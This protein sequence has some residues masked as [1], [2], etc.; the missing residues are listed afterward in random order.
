VIAV[1]LA[2]VALLLLAA[3]VGHLLCAR[4]GE[5]APAWAPAVGLA[6]LLVLARVAIE[7]PGRATTAALVVGVAGLACLATPGVRAALRAGGLERLLLALGVLLVASLPFL[8]NGRA[9]ILGMGDN[10][11]WS[12]HLTAA[13]WLDSHGTPVGIA[14]RLGHLPAQGYPLGP[15]ALAAA[16]SRGLGISLVH[17]LDA[18]TL[19]APVLTSL[20]ALALLPARLPR[21]ARVVAAAL[22]GLTYLAAS[23]LAQG[24]FKETLLATLLVAFVAGLR[25]LLARDRPGVR[26]GLSLG[27]LAAGTLYVYSL[28]GPL[29]PA[30]AVVAL[31][32]IEALR[33]R[34]LLATVRRVAPAA[35]GA[36]AA[37][38]VLGAFEI[39]HLTDFYSSS[40]A[41]EPD[42]GLGNLHGPLPALETLGL[43]PRGDFRFHPHPYGVAVA[44]DVLALVALAL[45]LAWWLRRRDNAVVA[46]LLGAG[47]IALW[48]DH[49]RSP[50]NTA[51]SL[52]V[53]APLVALTVAPL[54]AGA[55][56]RGAG[57]GAPALRALGVVV[58]AGATVSSFLALRDAPVGPTSHERQLRQLA[59]RIAGRSVLYLNS[60]D[61]A[62]WELR[63]T[64]AAVPP[65]LYAPGIAPRRPDKPAAETVPVDLDS[66]APATIDRYDYVI[67]S[68]AAYQSR[69]S[70]NLRPAARTADFILWRRAGITPP[71]SIIEP[72]Q[73]PGAVLDCSSNRGRRILAAGGT[74]ATLPT[75]VVGRRTA[76]SAQPFTSGKSAT[77]TLR[78][79]A[80]RWDVSLQYVSST[81][82]EIRGPGLSL[83]LPANLERLSNYWPA[84]TLVQPRGGPLT[85]RVTTGYPGAVGRLLGAPARTR[86]LGPTDHAPLGALALT[87]A[88]ARPRIVPLRQACGRYVDWYR[89][90]ARAS[91]STR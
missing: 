70:F 75:P 12:A 87:R 86:A 10:N 67:T 47:L 56:R 58:A 64:R 62:Q 65:L 43:W 57:R 90:G 3:A 13:W 21:A 55:W 28:P 20:A 6:A 91:A 7:L 51:K 68:A 69:P 76:W 71:R 80:G 74:A 31:L 4:G 42:E 41:N 16:T 48:S 11:D 54:L 59:T 77:Q 39:G 35:A 81:P 38:V 25:S 29:W 40:F 17:A 5:Q 15:H 82:L 66:F 18:V 22:V 19:L 9:G 1:Y 32:V 49:S 73:A 85:I 8:S 88:G 36:L 44:L 27:V 46:G 23:Y 72:A 61:F 26:A 33:P 83:H 14:A 78:V 63:G 50:Y 89:P 53:L 60:D 79:P 24:A 30:A 2:S 45:A 84:G 52:A 34:V 37:F